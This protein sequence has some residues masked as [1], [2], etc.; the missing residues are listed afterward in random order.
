MSYDK[1]VTYRDTIINGKFHV[2]LK[3][4]FW[5]HEVILFTRVSILEFKNQVN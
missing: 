2:A 1:N 4:N 3:N 5:S